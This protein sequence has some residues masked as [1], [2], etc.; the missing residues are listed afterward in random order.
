M[1]TEP[2]EDLRLVVVEDE[3]L[4]RDLLV[5]AIVSRIPGTS[6]VGSFATGEECKDAMPTLEA[7][8][9]VTDIDL[10]P[11][12][13]GPNLGVELRRTTTIRGVVLL[14][15]LALPSVLSS[16]PQDVSGGWAYL[17]KTSV[18]NVNQ[19]GRAIMNAAQGN[20]LIDDA[21]VDELQSTSE[22][23]LDRL[24]PRQLDVLSRIARGWSNRRIAEDLGLTLRSIESVIS[25]I[26]TN[27]DIREDIEGLNPRVRMV[28][29]YLENTVAKTWP[30]LQRG[31]EN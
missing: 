24:T 4:F 30:V 2:M 27:V 17:L 3:P 28:L 10:G 23:P 25:D 8:V 7:D 11:G 26:I 1:D 14:S 6:V 18:S 20:V 12:I 19:V 31:T 22:S 21:L 29:T 9:L 13:S 15:N 16:I 5:G